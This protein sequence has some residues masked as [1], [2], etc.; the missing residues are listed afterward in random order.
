MWEADAQLVEVADGRCQESCNGKTLQAL[1]M[2]MN[3]RQKKKL[4][5]YIE[6][7]DVHRNAMSELGLCMPSFCLDT[8]LSGRP[9]LTARKTPV[10]LSETL[11]R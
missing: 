5:M 10:W 6:E 2:R 3:E 1:D 8:L 4:L 9:I 7:N 11:G